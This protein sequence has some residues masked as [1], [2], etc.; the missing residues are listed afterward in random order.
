M[1]QMLETKFAAYFVQ[2]NGQILPLAGVETD[3][4]LHETVVEEF[5]VTLTAG[6][7]CQVL[8]D[9]YG[10]HFPGRGRCFLLNPHLLLPAIQEHQ[11]CDSA[12]AAVVRFDEK[13]W[14]DS[15]S[16]LAEA[17]GLTEIERR[18][19]MEITA[20]G[21][22]ET[23][24]T[25]ATARNAL[26]RVRR[27]LGTPNLAG[28]ITH[29]LELLTDMTIGCESIDKTA[30]ANV[31]GIPPRRFVILSLIAGGMSR[32]EVSKMTRST[33]ALIKA[34]LSLAYE[35]FDVRSASEMAA[36]VGQARIIAEEVLA[37]SARQRNLR[38]WGRHEFLVH[39]DGRR[40]GYSLYGQ[41]GSPLIHITHSNVTCRHPPT[42]LVTRLVKDG[43]QVLTIDRPGYGDTNT[44]SERSIDTHIATSVDD[45]LA[46]LRAKNLGKFTLVARNS[47]EI[48]ICFTNAIP[49]LVE[50]VVCINTVPPANR[51]TIDKGPLGALKRRFIR[52]PASIRLLI[53]TLLRLGTIER[54]EASARRSMSNSEPDL[55]ALDDPLVMEDYLASCLPLKKCLDGYTLEVSEWARGWE[56]VPKHRGEGW[57]ILLGAHFVLHDPHVA[58][59][60]LAE[61]L[62]EAKI[63]IV[64]DAGTLLA[65][66]HPEV[67]A[68]A[69]C[70]AGST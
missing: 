36:I 70:R 58:A 66:S 3:L 33:V 16:K 59:S 46:V 12:V 30:L 56:P 62:P 60:Y 48:A 40:V 25:G 1:Q 17:Y 38:N 51:T 7:P 31:L 39:P 10:K 55:Y 29:L 57:T 6:H 49:D 13:F 15:H 5:A 9:A 61:C 64:R 63:Q 52:Y 35:M 21:T 11:D 28:T 20:N 8:S 18:M 2:R 47:T 42:R 32:T 54:I 4:C 41:P 43:Y 67:I 34:E 45:L 50:K 65:W 44:A 23:F 53:G 37:T 27:K 19:A 68:D 22:S 14:V 69:F 26:V 24:G